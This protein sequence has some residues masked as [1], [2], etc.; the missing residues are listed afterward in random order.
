MPEAR[1]IVTMDTGGD[2]IPH[3]ARESHRDYAHRI[4]AAYSRIR[5]APR[6]VFTDKIAGLAGLAAERAIWLDGDTIVRADCPDL[7]ELVPAHRFGGVPNY[8]PSLH[9][10][11]PETH[12]LQFW[13]RARRLLESS[14][15]YDPATY[16]NGGVLVFSPHAHREVWRIPGKLLQG[17]VHPMYEQSWLNQRLQDLRIPLEL[18]PRSYNTMGPKA[19]DH[20]EGEPMAAHI[21]HLAHVG[22]YRDQ[23]RR[24]RLL[25]TIDWRALP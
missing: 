14:A 2:W 24:R 20:P 19:W 23:K 3:N 18:L 15:A 7:F 17:R 11:N 12:H 8:H 6:G 25:E 21:Y 4:G 16:V 13:D 5:A 9:G 10:P 22:R 1:V